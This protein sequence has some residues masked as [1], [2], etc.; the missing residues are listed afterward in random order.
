MSLQKLT[1][2]NVRNIQK[3]T[4]IP[5]PGLNLIYGKNASGKSALLEAIFLLG[6]ARSYRTTTIKHSIKYDESQLTVSGSVLLKNGIN[7][8]LGIQLDGKS[9][10]I[11]I[12][13]QS[14]QSRDLLAYSLPILLID[15][16]SYR[17][18]DAGAQIRREF[19]D[20]GIF[21]RNEHFLI[22]WR[23]YKRA[24][25]QRNALLKMRNIKQLEV[26]TNELVNYG[27]IVNEHRQLYVQNLLP[28]FKDVLTQFISLDD[29]NFLF[30]LGWDKSKGFLSSLNNDLEKDMRYG[31]THSG[32]HRSDLLLL[33]GQRL[34]K[35]FVSRGQLKCIVLALKLA[36]IKLMVMEHNNNGCILID[37]F[38]AE[39]DWVNRNKLLSYLSQL[40]FQVFLTA[41]EVN[42][43][44]D[45][46]G[47]N[48]FK[49]FH[50]K[51]GE[52][53]EVNSFT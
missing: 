8:Q 17:L 29:I 48:N 42:E 34:A 35:D 12:N 5:S 10:E 16:K 3:A 41:T 49:M 22:A 14:Q 51:Q 47:L 9:S 31:F 20:W 26:W 4:L 39:L 11:R 52:I 38:T 19:I 43:F 24:L 2:Y 25:Q 30:Q 1:I 46:S 7:C 33:I 13:H 53:D 40:S 21:N 44:G 28:V 23:N 37:D 18:L 32:P 45:I 50:V 6:R 36:Q 15:P 27:I